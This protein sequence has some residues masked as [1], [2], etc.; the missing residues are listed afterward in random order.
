MK[1]EHKDQRSLANEL[2]SLRQ[3]RFYLAIMVLLL[4]GA[5]IWVLIT[6][7]DPGDTTEVSTDALK[8][9][10]PINPNLDVAVFATVENKRLLTDAELENFPINRLVKDRSG[11]YTVIP[12]DTS[13]EEV[14][15][16]ATG[17]RVQPTPVAAPAGA[18]PATSS[19]FGTLTP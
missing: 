11:N 16:I 19:A 18:R 3:N 17:T 7:M 14:E 12:Y 6:I 8:Y 10:V 9:S 4:A 1:A 15:E 2:A 5:L 13:K